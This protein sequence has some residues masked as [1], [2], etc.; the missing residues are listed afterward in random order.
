LRVKIAAK[1]KN[2]S[3]SGEARS[4]AELEFGTTA[5]EVEAPAED[6]RLPVVPAPPVVD[7]LPVLTVPL[8]AP[9]VDGAAVLVVEFAEL[10]VRDS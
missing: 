4:E 10:A 9:V 1:V 5:V 3:A 6:V 8:V 2:T 7:G